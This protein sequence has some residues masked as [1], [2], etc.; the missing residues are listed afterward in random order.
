MTGSSSPSR[1]H[2]ALRY[3]LLTLLLIQQGCGLAQITS[4]TDV[5]QLPSLPGSIQ[6]GWNVEFVY[7][8]LGGFI[9]AEAAGRQIKIAVRRQGDDSV[10]CSVDGGTRCSFSTAGFSEGI[11][12]ARVIADDS[13]QIAPIN[14]DFFKEQSIDL[15][16]DNLDPPPPPPPLSPGPGDGPRPC[17]G[18][19]C[20]GPDDPLGEPG[21]LPAMGPPGGPTPDGGP[22]PGS[23]PGPGA[24]G[25]PTDPDSPLA[26]MAP[27]NP[28]SPQETDGEDDSPETPPKGGLS[29][30]PVKKAP[31][32]PTPQGGQV[33]DPVLAATGEMLL[34]VQDASFRIRSGDRF[35]LLRT[36]RSKSSD[37]RGWFGHGFRIP[38]ER[39]VELFQGVLRETDGYGNIYDYPYSGQP[40]ARIFGTDPSTAATV[41]QDATGDFHIVYPG[42]LHLHYH[43]TSGRLLSAI[44]VNGNG[45]LMTYGSQG[46]PTRIEDT[47]GRAVL[48]EVNP[49]G[50][51]SSV[52]LPDGS[53]WGY[54]YSSRGE[55]VSVRD[56]RNG[57]SV[58]V[59]GGSVGLITGSINPVG[60]TH[61]WTYD[62]QRRVV[63]LRNELGAESTF[64]YLSNPFRTI[65]EDSLH[66]AWTYTFDSEGHVLEVVGPDGA[67][68]RNTFD[69]GGR[70][71]RIEDPHGR[72]STYAY[73]SHG[74]LAQA[75]D[76]VGNVK[77]WDRSG[78]LG[79][80]VSRTDP[81]GA[82]SHASFDG[83]GNALSVT[84]ATGRNS[85]TY[86][87]NARGQIVSSRDASG[88]VTLFQYGPRGERESTTD[89]LGR[90]WSQTHDPLSRVTSRTDPLG[91]T[92]TYQYWL[93]E[94]V[95]VTT[96]PLGQTVTAEFDAALQRVRVIDQK[97][98][99]TLQVW[100]TINGRQALLSRTDREGHTWTFEYDSE[101]R[102]TATVDPR[103]A[104]TETE[105]D[106]V[107]RPV[108][109]RD[110]LGNESTLVWNPDGTLHSTTDPLGN[111]RVRLY[112]TKRRLQYMVDPAGG[113]ETLVY[114]SR[115]RVV[116]VIDQNGDETQFVFD[117]EDRLVQTIDPEGGITENTYDAR[118]LLI[119]T[120]DPRGN[121]TLLIRD[122][123]GR[124]K[125][126]H[127]AEGGVTRS[128][129]N[130]AGELIRTVDAL[131][132]EVQFERDALGRVVRQTGP[133]GETTVITYTPT[134]RVASTEDPDGGVQRL[135]YDLEDRL[136]ESE[137]ELGFLV[138][139]TLDP[140]GNLI[141]VR[142]Q[143]DN[144]TTFEVDLLGRTTAVIDAAGQAV[145]HVFD[146]AGR[147]IKTTN[148]RAQ[149]LVFTWDERSL[150]RRKDTPETSETYDYDPVGRRV[151]RTNAH[152]DEA[153]FFDRRGLSVGTIDFVRGFTSTHTRDVNGNIIGTT[154]TLGGETSRTYDRENRLTSI[155]SSRGEGF[156]L[157]YSPAG[158]L[159]RRASSTRGIEVM[160]YD[161]SGRLAA[162]ENRKFEDQALQFRLEYFYSPAG[163]RIREIERRGDG[164]EATI[165]YEYNRRHELTRAHVTT[166]AGV[167][168]RGFQEISWTYDPAGNRLSQVRDGVSTTYT[169]NALNQVTSINGRPVE[170]DSD[171]NTLREPIDS[172]R[173]RVYVWNAQNQMVQT[174]VS[175]GGV[176]E[177]I[178]SYR[179]SP[180]GLRIASIEE[181]D[182]SEPSRPRR[183]EERMFSF[184]QL[185]EERSFV[186]G[187]EASQ[188]S[189]RRYLRHGSSVLEEIRDD[190]VAG[191]PTANPSRFYLQDGLGSSVGILSGAGSGTSERP[192]LRLVSTSASNI[193]GNLDSGLPTLSRN[194]RFVA[195]LSNATNLVD[196]DTN[197]Q[198]DVFVKDL[199][200][201]D[202]DRVSVTTAG[203]QAID[204]PT[205]DRLAISDDG[206]FVAFNHWD[207]RLVP[208]GTGIGNLI[209]VVYLRDR[210]ARTTQRV[211]Q[212]P[213]G[214]QVAGFGPAISGDGRFVA[215]EARES[216]IPEDTSPFGDIYLFD[217]ET[218]SYELVSVAMGGGP[219]NNASWGASVSGDG[220]F[221][222]FTSAADNLVP[223]DTNGGW[224]VYVRDR[225]S[226]T[227][228]RVSV[229][230]GGVQAGQGSHS[231]AITADGRYVAFQSEATDLIPGGDGREPDIF[232]HDRD[233]S[234]TVKI[235][236]SPNF[237][238]G[239]AYAPVSL[240]NDG[241]Y[242][243]YSANIWSGQVPNDPNFFDD[244]FLVVQDTTTQQRV[245]VS[246]GQA[247]ES[248]NS[249]SW[250]PSISGDGKWIAFHSLASNLVPGD[251]NGLLDVFVAFNPT[252]ELETTGPGE[253]THVRYTPFGERVIG[254]TDLTFTHQ[255][256][257][258][259]GLGD[260]TDELLVAQFRDA[261]PGS[262]RWTSRDPAGFLDGPNRYRWNRNNPFRYRDLNGQL[263]FAVVFGAGVD[264]ALG[265]LGG[266]TSP[267]ALGKRALRGGLVGGA[268]IFT[269]AIVAAESGI[270]LLGAI[271]TEAMALGTLDR[272]LGNLLGIGC[273]KDVISTQA[274]KRDVAFGA[275]ARILARLVQ[276]LAELGAAEK[277]A[278]AQAK[279]PNKAGRIEQH[280]V[281]PKYL[282]GDPRGPR[283]P[284]DA[285]YHQEITN[286]FRDLWPY[287]GR[288]PTPAELEQ[289]KRQVYDRFPL[290]DGD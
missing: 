212:Y 249:H 129:W 34:Q 36:Y 28:G 146:A 206:R 49:E 1:I 41:S 162:V 260:A 164:S 258:R 91:R 108:L 9:T 52:T 286:A 23:P 40:Q 131:G 230:S 169:V 8:E 159:L 271:A 242:V 237:P 89:P 167:I 268:S 141:A 263:P 50:F 284:L 197:N 211:S 45:F 39:R 228:T 86:V 74:L 192:P 43:E 20:D 173:D 175:Q 176:L 72:V 187:Q 106:L 259:E 132:R 202:V 118:G 140:V 168:L 73:E 219:A 224:D 288:K 222:S 96:D 199:L 235:S 101:G 245:L 160:E 12:P 240:S 247:G 223:G 92:W 250:F 83:Q 53:T 285:A 147:R 119:A 77:Q 152:S 253:V 70:V 38:Y 163:D 10:L 156:V 102:H 94:L 80:A 244:V 69:S 239:V 277:L 269:G 4:L 14:P 138:R 287:G 120:R 27:L 127:L 275:A 246:L 115:D 97:A 266:E 148:S 2:A 136:V 220:R 111:T 232:M 254:P 233:T 161:L 188:A 278:A 207:W 17:A 109:V 76:P 46:V 172:I 282:G 79:Q 18:L 6:V 157:T 279:Y 143:N 243:V 58:Y 61:S 289:I 139:R 177:D 241:R 265:I 210:L 283:V 217:R 7:W 151:R 133:S 178:F 87:R 203:G 98:A 145:R 290:P 113:V 26:P 29:G 154:D 215:F 256:L 100:R 35:R 276:R 32:A 44:D 16:V 274:L 112:D 204:P 21:P 81:D 64:Q 90:V 19:D 126:T 208:G 85:R 193:Q 125:E 55:L 153:T 186:E 184:G 209:P 170:Y 31:D 128:F 180:D 144:V 48:F 103:G 110:A 124:V 3:L 196:G 229:A 5:Q 54:Q 95:H 234:T 183:F 231:S 155:V 60:E 191:T 65:Y 99:S 205:Q 105:Y 51:V 251:S 82:V 59:Y 68:W 116:A 273:P 13:L 248:G 117:A 252:M 195:F 281:D 225:H 107:S 264:V 57:L 257:K 62:L 33:G 121:Q 255:G 122:E 104:R 166:P 88:A 15:I 214:G 267:W 47:D 182:A 137:D 270:A 123:L 37:Y 185:A 171:G 71:T 24:P 261:R 22:C 262:G 130:E 181:P 238:G 63:S 56:P 194:G 67:V 213:S 75:T 134:G 201:G 84:D 25:G 165:E 280:H 221:V 30:C 198:N 200:T 66:Q 179:Y 189:S 218:N 236:A 150:L 190:L 174:A 142:D 42:G 93:N 227:T 114:D 272:G 11:L 226:G 78:P 158:E 216:L 149:D 135:R